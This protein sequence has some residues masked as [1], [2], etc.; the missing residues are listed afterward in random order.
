M[1]DLQTMSPEAAYASKDNIVPQKSYTAVRTLTV[2]ADGPDNPNAE[3]TLEDH[4]PSGVTLTAA[5][6]T[7]KGEGLTATT[8][9]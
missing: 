1:A 6:M 7:I 5:S 4:L 3:A 2:M 8:G 9:V